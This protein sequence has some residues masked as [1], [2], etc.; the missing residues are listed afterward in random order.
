MNRFAMTRAIAAA[1]LIALAGC[2]AGSM[3]GQNTDQIDT[4]DEAVIN[5]LELQD[6]GQA[7]TQ[8]EEITEG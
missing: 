8:I 3:T 5:S 7:T 2:A 6:G 1:G 4:A